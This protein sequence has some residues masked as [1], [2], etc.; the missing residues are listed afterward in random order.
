MPSEHKRAGQMFRLNPDAAVV[1][2][3]L[4]GARIFSASC[5]VSGDELTLAH[6]CLTP[7]ERSPSTRQGLRVCGALAMRYLLAAASAIALSATVAMAQTD[8]PSAT[9]DQQASAPADANAA[10]IAKSNADKAG[11]EAQTAAINAQKAMYDAQTAA[12][13]SKAAASGATNGTV[14]G[15]AFATGAVTIGDAGPKSEALLLVSRA[16]DQATDKATQ[17]L[18]PFLDR[19]PRRPILVITDPT[20]VATIHVV[21]FDTQVQRLLDG[22]ATAH[23]GYETLAHV[24]SP[25]FTTPGVAAAEARTRMAVVA[26]ASAADAVL[27]AASKL[28]SYFLTDYKYGDVQVTTVPEMYAASLVRRLGPT[29]YGFVSPGNVNPDGAALVRRL[30]QLDVALRTAVSDHSAATVA[31]TELTAQAGT[32]TAH[33]DELKAL[34]AAYAASATTTQ[35][36]V[37]AANTFMTGILTASADKPAPIAQIIQEDNVRTLIGNKAIVLY[38]TG[39]PTAAYYTEKNLWTFFGGVPIYT[40]G[41]TVVTLKLY[42]P[43]SG[44]VFYWGSGS[45]HGGYYSVRQVA[46]A[47]APAPSK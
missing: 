10:A 47:F 17:D 42:D 18:K 34:A 21:V 14:N 22:L 29:Q 2:T 31:A 4:A 46:S 13:Q 44:E 33:A 27:S 41:G 43:V 12:S 3:R 36:L 23:Q 7:R 25:K 5:E 38:V 15:T 20:Q 16:I 30:G 19:Q 40:M 1:A 32:D 35:T 6:A 11:F 28:G 37:D 39:Q 8:T 24:P 9:P 26:A 45:A